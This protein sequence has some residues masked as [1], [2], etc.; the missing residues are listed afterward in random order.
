MKKYQDKARKYKNQVKALKQQL[1]SERQLN[2]NLSSYSSDRQRL[3]SPT[4]IRGNNQQ[5]MMDP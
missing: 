1:T 5:E 3:S 2:Q 4:T